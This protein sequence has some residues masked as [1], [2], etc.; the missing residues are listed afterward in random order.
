[1]VVGQV[2]AAPPPRVSDDKRMLK[3]APTRSELAEAEVS[4]ARARLREARANMTTDDGADAEGDGNHMSCAGEVPASPND[5]VHEGL[6]HVLEAGK[7]M[8]KWKPR[9]ARVTRET[10]R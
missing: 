1:M 2:P 4:R 6:V 8:K 9:F 5:V 10:A 7:F 3:R